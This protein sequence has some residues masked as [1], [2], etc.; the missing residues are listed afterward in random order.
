MLSIPQLKRVANDDPYLYEALK[1]IA[2]AINGL[3]QRIG[4][5]PTGAVASPPAIAKLAVTAADGIFD[6]AITDAPTTLKHG[7]W[8]F[9]EYDT[10]PAFP[11]PRVIFLGPT[12][13]AR[14]QL[15]NQTLYW[16]AYSQYFSSP[17]SPA[18]TFGSPPTA[19]TG[20]GSSGPTPQPSQ[21]SGTAPPDQGGSGFGK[22]VGGRIVIPL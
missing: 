5:D 20:G 4:V 16:R 3:N 15:G 13:N 10:S 8:Y 6:V 7:I 11:M 12:R 21:G 22:T 9:L 18:V 2:G 1:K 19:V 17:P 14:L